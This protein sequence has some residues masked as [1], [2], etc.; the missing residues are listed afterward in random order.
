MHG[1][2]TLQKPLRY[3]VQR[4]SGVSQGLCLGQGPRQ[5][6]QP[7]QNSSSHALLSEPEDPQAQISLLKAMI[8]GSHRDLRCL[9]C[10]FQAYLI[11]TKVEVGLPFYMWH[12]RSKIHV[13]QS[14][15]A[16]L[17]A[18][19]PVSCHVVIFKAAQ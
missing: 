5:P 2:Q 17:Q 16:T 9:L 6:S 7:L 14:Q 19:V 10:G 15:A 8:Q 11:L 13:L 18:S 12:R 4:A 3:G 1:Q